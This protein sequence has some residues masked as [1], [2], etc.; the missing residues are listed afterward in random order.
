MGQVI[1]ELM[2]FKPE[3]VK[4]LDQ[5]QSPDLPDDDVGDL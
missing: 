1:R 2:Q 3:A 4:Y 5:I